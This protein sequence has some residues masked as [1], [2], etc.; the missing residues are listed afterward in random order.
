MDLR[1]DLERNLAELRTRIER[2]AHRSGRTPADVTLV[3]VTKTLPPETVQLANEIGVRDFGEN[4]ANEL[5]EKALETSRKTGSA[6][7]DSYEKTAIALADSYV[8]TAQSAHVDWISNMAVAQA[9][10]AR[11]LAKT[12]VAA[13]R[14]YVD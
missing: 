13:A 10:V 4:H 3:A 6:L 8:K 7:L 12:Y 5:S 9:D 11:E 2:A 14:T 1:G